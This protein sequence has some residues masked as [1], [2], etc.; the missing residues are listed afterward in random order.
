M[1]KGDLILS[2]VKPEAWPCLFLEPMGEVRP[3][4]VVREL[5]RH[6]LVRLVTEDNGPILLLEEDDPPNAN[7]M[8]GFLLYGHGDGIALDNLR[9]IKVPTH[10]VKGVRL[11]FFTWLGEF[12]DYP[13]IKEISVIHPERIPSFFNCF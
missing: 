3:Y 8:Y 9:Y 4:V 5:L 1:E 6:D 2:S 10:F 13:S 12:V 11:N 7:I